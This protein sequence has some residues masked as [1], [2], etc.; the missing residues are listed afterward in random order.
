M[1]NDFYV[2]EHIRSDTGAVFYVG[3]GRGPR[4]WKFAERNGHYGNILRKLER[5]GGS[6][7]VRLVKEGLPESCAFTLER[8]RI[9][10]LRDKGVRL[11]NKTDGGEG[12]SG[13]NPTK[14][15]RALKSKQLRARWANPAMRAY[16]SSRMKAL[17][18]D[19]EYRAAQAERLKK[20]WED[21]DHRRLAASERLTEAWADPEFRKAQVALRYARWADPENKAKAR[22]AQAWRF[23][24]VRCLE[25]G[26]VYESTR[27]AARG[28]DAPSSHVGEVCKGRRKSV[29]G[30]RFEYVE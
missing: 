1:N 15:E 28:V 30:F 13:Y 23:K 20:S 11:T 4:A 26:T 24:A 27:A 19:P 14:R 10:V 8:L 25:T 7:D 5:D 18:E 2:Y 6:V 17:H 16:H 22:A 21:E 9:R 3:K 29:K 12:A